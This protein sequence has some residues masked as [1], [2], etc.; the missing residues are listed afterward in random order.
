MRL[1]KTI[2]IKWSYIFGIILFSF[3]NI[4][5]GI[6]FL[7]ILLIFAVVSCDFIC[8]PEKEAPDN[9]PDST[10]NDSGRRSYMVDSR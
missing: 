8:P 9:V 2:Q 4:R 1:A 10:L 3:M 5:K 6:L 7:V